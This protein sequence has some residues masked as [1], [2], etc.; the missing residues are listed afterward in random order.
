MPVFSVITGFQLQLLLTE[1]TLNRSN[2]YRIF[3]HIPHGLYTSLHATTDITCMVMRATG[4]MTTNNQHAVTSSTTCSTVVLTGWPLSAPGTVKFPRSYLD[5]SQ[6]SK[7]RC[8]T[9]I[10]HTLPVHYKREQIFFCVSTGNKILN[11][12]DTRWPAT[13]N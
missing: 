13:V 10:I 12:G 9:H 8:V 5:S 1:N 3:A 7:P 2:M 11:T 6:H 4:H